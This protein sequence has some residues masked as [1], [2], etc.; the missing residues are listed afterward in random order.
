MSQ[1]DVP[2]ADILQRAKTVRDRRHVLEE[3]Q[4][5]VDREIQD[6]GN[7]LSPV[8]DFER[9]TVVALPLALLA[10]HVDVRE[11]VHFDRDHAVALDTS[12]SVHP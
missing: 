1:L 10:R 3:W 2:E 11:K 9:F 7:G 8:P 5:L 6:L 4:R 12:R